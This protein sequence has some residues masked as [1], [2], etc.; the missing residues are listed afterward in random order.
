MA[1]WFTPLRLALIFCALDLAWAFQALGSAP[2][3]AGSNVA[4][5]SFTVWVVTHLPAAILASLLF[6]AAGTLD[7]P[8]GTP[9]LWTYGVMGALGLCQTFT[10]AFG[11]AVWLRRDP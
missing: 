11:L 10:L 7:G 2:H 5:V 9:P 3:R 6:K 1:R 4:M 8:A